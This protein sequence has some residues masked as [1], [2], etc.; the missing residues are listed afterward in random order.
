ML[1]MSCS[2]QLAKVSQKQ[3]LMQEKCDYLTRAFCNSRSNACSQLADRQKLMSAGSRLLC[4]SLSL[5]RGG[6]LSTPVQNTASQN[7]S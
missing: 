3:A 1:S 2:L 4:P 7:H 5:P 6:K